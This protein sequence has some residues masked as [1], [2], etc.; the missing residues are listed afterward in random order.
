M[1]TVAGLIADLAAD[2]RWASVGGVG[3]GSAGPVDPSR[4]TV[5]P[6][7]IPA[8]RDFPLVDR[9]ARLAPVAQGGHA[10]TAG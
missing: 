3:I 1:A 6:V 10:A 7:N 9:V 4:G 8:W 2:P 5:S